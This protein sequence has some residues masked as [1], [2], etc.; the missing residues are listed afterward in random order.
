MQ[1][2]TSTTRDKTAKIERK[3]KKW[4]FNRIMDIFKLYFVNISY[5]GKIIISQ[6]SSILQDG[7]YLNLRNI[8]R[9]KNIQNEF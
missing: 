4:L 5:N 9:L 3:V 6:M 2:M 1:K 7:Q 8:I